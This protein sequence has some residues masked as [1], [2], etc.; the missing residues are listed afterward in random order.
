MTRRGTVTRVHRRR[1]M[2]AVQT[3]DDG[4]TIIELRSSNEVDVGDELE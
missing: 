4:F 3:Y 1:A 2:G